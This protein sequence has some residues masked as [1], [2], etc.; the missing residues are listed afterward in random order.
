[1]IV[2]TPIFRSLKRINPSLTIGVF[3]SETNADIIR[4]NPYVDSVYVLHSNWFKL[5]G[6]ILK[7]RKERYALILNLIF[8][9]TTSGGILANIVSPSGIKVGQGDEKYR[10]YFNRLLKIRRTNRHM[11]DSFVYIINEVFAIQLEPDQLDYEIYVD[12]KTKNEVR[13]YLLKNSLQER[14]QSLSGKSCYL[15]FNLSANDSVRRISADQAYALGNHLGSI[16][17]FRTVLLHAPLDPAMLVVKQNLVNNSGCLSF[18]ERGNASLLELASLIEGAL[19]VVTPDTSIIHFAS[20]MSTPVVGFYT[21]MQDV[22][23]WLP[24]SV[25]NRVV[26]SSAHEPT[27]SIPIPE[28]IQAVDEFIQGL[29][30]ELP[31]KRI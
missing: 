16:T 28:M 13:K 11:I 17:S 12:E 25:K 29:E 6:E 5:I 15:V 24:R 4:Y 1:M 9:R 21:R 22:H 18:P 20:A 23:E 26:L 31:S 19:V 30:R 7:A 27:G 8:N 10:F 3:A 14:S 2:T